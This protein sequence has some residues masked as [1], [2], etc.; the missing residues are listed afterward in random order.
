M[1][2][3]INISHDENT[4]TVNDEKA[5]EHLRKYK[6]SCEDEG[7]FAFNGRIEMELERLEQK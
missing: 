1:S 7:E 2:Y 3:V 6:D 5:R 4:T